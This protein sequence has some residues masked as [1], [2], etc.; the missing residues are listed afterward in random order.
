MRRDGWFAWCTNAS[1]A[2]TF[3]SRSAPGNQKLDRLPADAPS[4]SVT[5]KPIAKIGDSRSAKHEGRAPDRASCVSVLDRE[6]QS[7]AAFSATPLAPD[8]RQT[9]PIDER[10]GQGGS[11]DKFSVRRC[12]ADER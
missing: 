9:F 10:I 8:E 12:F 11:A 4:A 6:R 7:L 2:S 3:I 5:H 1:I